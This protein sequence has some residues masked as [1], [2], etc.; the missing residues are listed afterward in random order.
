MTER[1]E[2]LLEPG[3]VLHQRPYRNTSLIVDCLTAPYGRQVLI[4]RGARRPQVRQRR[5]LQPFQPVLL[6]WVRRSEMGTLT[7]IES[8]GPAIGL[9]GDCLLAGFY[10]NELLLR[11]VPRGDHNEEIMSCY[12]SCLDRLSRN[13][14]P[15]RALRIFEMELLAAL[16]YR[17][18]LEHDFR[19][20][21]SIDPERE[22]C[23]ESEGGLTAIDN[24][25]AMSGISGRHIISLREH[26]LEDAESQRA[27]RLMLSA[28][29]RAHLGDRPL[30]SRDVLREMAERGL[31]GE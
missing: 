18:D 7:D 2:V 14:T 3:F 1:E 22:Y 26:V 10:L 17:L 20:G 25:R 4:A 23:F 16:G 13:R 24:K 30:K 9:R 12:S 29:L 31:V 15:A 19:T 27:A 6:S 5:V 8:G 11:L 28:I 21:E